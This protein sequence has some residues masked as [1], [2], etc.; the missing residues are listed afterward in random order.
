MSLDT[1]LRKV[2]HTYLSDSRRTFSYCLRMLSYRLV[3]VAWMASLSA[4]TLFLK[5]S[6]VA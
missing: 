1:S 5:V 2:Q 6:K 4:A 3:Q